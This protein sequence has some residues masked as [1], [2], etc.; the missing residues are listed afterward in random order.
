M[1][2]FKFNILLCRRN[3]DYSSVLIKCI[4]EKLIMGS[5]YF[6]YIASTYLFPKS[7]SFFLLRWYSCEL[8][9]WIR[10]NCLH[11]SVLERWKKSKKPHTQ[12]KRNNR[13]ISKRLWKIATK[14]PLFNSIFVNPFNFLSPSLN[15]LIY[16]FLS[17]PFHTLL[18]LNSV[19]LHL[20]SFWLYVQ[21][22]FLSV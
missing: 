22:C 8:V 7:S 11:R 14:P 20:F 16:L 2:S 17:L 19:K 1:N 21:F 18:L 10:P 13:R 3:G 12:L 15:N 5:L 6:L 9:F 4:H